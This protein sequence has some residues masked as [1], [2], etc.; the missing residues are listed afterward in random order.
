[1][2]TAETAAI[3]RLVDQ[4]AIEADRRDGAALAALFVEEGRLLIHTDGDADGEPTGQRGGRA[5]IAAAIDT[6][7]RY[8]RTFHLVGQH[9][10]EIVD[11]DHATAVTHCQAHHVTVADDGSASDYVMH[12]RYLDEFVRDEGGDWRFETRRLVLDFV[13]DHPI[14][15]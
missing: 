13:D 4:Y 1:L 12:I 9:V 10:A 7:A 11:E 14:K 3:R 5:E 6:L 8:R 2:A 15:G